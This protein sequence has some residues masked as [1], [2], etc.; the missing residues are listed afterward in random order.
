MRRHLTVSQ[1]AVLAIDLL[2]L[3]EEEAKEN[4]RKAAERTNAILSG[5]KDMTLEEKFPQAIEGD[6]EVSRAKQSSEMVAKKLR[7]NP[8][9]VSDAKRILVG[10]GS[11]EKAK[12]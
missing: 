9:Y 7:I 12:Q 11:G 2:P 3:A 6:S 5:S 1:K 8:H 4:Q 10:T